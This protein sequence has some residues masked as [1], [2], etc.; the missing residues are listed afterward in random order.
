MDFGTVRMRACDLRAHAQEPL[1]RVRV[2]TDDAVLSRA[3]E[4]VL[5]DVTAL[6]RTDS[7]TELDGAGVRTRDD[8]GRLARAAGQHL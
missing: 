4:D 7:G 5:A 1:F 2:L 3:V 8:I 6:S